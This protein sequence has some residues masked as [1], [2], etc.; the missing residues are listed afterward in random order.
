MLADGRR[1]S[2]AVGGEE[3]IL[4]LDGQTSLV[5]ATT[6]PD[7]FEARV[8][9]DRAFPAAAFLPLLAH[10]FSHRQR[11]DKITLSLPASVDWA[12]EAVRA[13][14]FQTVSSADGMTTLS[15]DRGAFWQ[16]PQPWLAGTTS[17]TTPLVYVMTDGKRHPR[18]PAKPVGNVYR[19]YMPRLA[20]TFSMR[21]IDIDRDVEI[22]NRW[23]N[24][25]S[26]AEFWNERGSLDEHRAYLQK[27]M[28]DPHTISM[29][30]C[31]DDEPFAYFEVYWAKEDRIA[32]FYD[33]DD[34][35]R[36]AH[37]LVGDP[38]HQG[39]RK[40]EAW[41]RALNHYLFLDDPRTRRVVGDPRI[42]HVRWIDY[43]QR[44]GL[45]RLKE[46]DLPHKRSALIL[47]ER[48]TFFGPPWGGV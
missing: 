34:Y 46:F 45:V 3:A 41:F 9:P 27:V 1:V 43:M 10:K 40:V 20:T 39:P 42:D 8:A 13:G 12:R 36:G 47:A 25:D 24:L 14:V 2:V 16:L 19:R 5:L 37:L 17:A 32:P 21:A 28:D 38:R 7:R 30:G 6:A 15:V 4:L 26:V 22:F 33:V 29:F 48:E 35:D 23:M 31:F 18:R 44:Q 11:P